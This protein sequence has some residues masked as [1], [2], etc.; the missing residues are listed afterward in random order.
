MRRR[1][2]EGNLRYDCEWERWKFHDH[3]GE[4]YGMSC[5]DLV[6]LLLFGVWQS[7]RLEKDHNGWYITDNICTVYLRPKTVY[8]IRTD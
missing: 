1:L 8:R 4:R 7:C 5:G 6:E 2:E 3:T